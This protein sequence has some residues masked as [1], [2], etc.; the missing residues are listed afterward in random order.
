M[1][2]RGDPWT[3]AVAYL[4]LACATGRAAPV[5]APQPADWVP[6]R[7]PW[8]DPASLELLSGGPV[9]CLLVRTYT[10]EFAAAAAG[11]GVAT[12]ALILPADDAPET[13]RRALAAGVAG[14]ALE[15]DFTEAAVASVRQAAG[16]APVI[17]LAPR[18]RMIRISGAPVRATCQG[19]WPGVAMQ[20]N[21]AMRAG[22]SGSVWVDTNTGFLRAAR[23]SGG[24]SLW[25]AEQPPPRT[26]VT[27]GRYLVAIAD[28][29]M[30]GARWVLALD[31]GFSARLAARETGALADWRRMFD[32]IRYFEEHPEWREMRE[33]GKLALVQDPAKGGLIS[34]GI[35][36]MIAARNTPVRL[37]PHELL[38]PEA[39]KDA[40]LAVNLDS[41]AL[42][43]AEQ[44][45]LRAFTRSGGTLLTA[46]PWWKDQAPAGNA[47]TLGK[48]ELAQ[49]ND[50][51]HDV[52]ST[53]GRR[54][55]G[56]RLFNAS[57][58]L[59][60]FLIS[61]DG[62]RAVLHLVNYSDY[63]V[64]NVTAQFLDDFHHAAL[65]APG[66][67][68]RPLDLHKTDEG[69]EADIDKVSVCAAIR[70]ER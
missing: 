44:D 43:P 52:N 65:L 22:P 17:E 62:K 63:P 57:A 24:A 13:A 45:A 54:N 11:R 56:V 60:N 12:L 38:A 23:A 29:A 35:L 4:A 61:A 18:S 47:I 51:F 46:P 32:L 20:E 30:S 7:W 66:G 25:I 59:S 14:I 58:M 33:Y 40:S 50:I 42:T 68:E 9:N 49:L 3:I 26:V 34:G 41:A 16:G 39:L 1:G 21:G 19:V 48:T 55:L 37:I 70:L 31:D 6:A 27:G 64:E 28:A 69:W 2:M 8:S 53:I 67:A 36:D 15:G 5:L 10:A